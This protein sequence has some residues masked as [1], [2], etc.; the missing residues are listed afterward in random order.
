MNKIIIEVKG[1]IIQA[2]HTSENSQIVILD[3]DNK[4]PKEYVNG[5][6][7]V[8]EPDSI[9]KHGDIQNKVEVLNS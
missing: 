8:Y 6:F 1:G 9:F 2:V 7:G 4:T 5:D 3:Y